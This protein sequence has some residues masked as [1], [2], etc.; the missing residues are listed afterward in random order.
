MPRYEKV[1]KTKSHF[2]EILLDGKLVITAEGVRAGP[3]APWSVDHKSPQRNLGGQAF[4]DKKIASLL[5]KN[6]KLV[7]DQLEVVKPPAPKPPEEIERAKRIAEYSALLRANGNKVLWTGKT[8]ET[9][10]ELIEVSVEGSRVT[11]RL[12]KA[13]QPDRFEYGNRGLEDLALQFAAKRLLE[14]TANGFGP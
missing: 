2:F 9:A 7:G 11:I 4:Y 8:P 14:A 13:G 5:A 10:D 3:D 6:Y 12:G 1:G